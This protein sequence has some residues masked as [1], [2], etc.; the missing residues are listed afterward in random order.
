MPGIVQNI[1][2]FVNCLLVNTYKHQKRDKIKKFNSF[3]QQLF[4]FFFR[5]RLALRNFPKGV[6]KIK[7]RQDRVFLARTPGDPNRLS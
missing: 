6:E 1:I 3:A 2:K 5:V 7:I 4:S